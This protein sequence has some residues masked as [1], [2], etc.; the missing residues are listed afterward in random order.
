MLPAAKTILDERL[1]R[2]AIS[3]PMER[4]SLPRSCTTALS[5]VTR[6]PLIWGL[7]V[8][9]CGG[10]NGSG[11]YLHTKRGARPWRFRGRGIF[12]QNYGE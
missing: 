10:P 6:S 4:G 3:R 12:N 9:S 11:R 5:R 1:D 8:Y 7:R 2:R